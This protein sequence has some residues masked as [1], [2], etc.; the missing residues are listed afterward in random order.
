M[1][2]VFRKFFTS[3]Y[4][5]D[6]EAAR[7]SR[8]LNY[9]LWVSIGLLVIS[10]ILSFYE[11]KSIT[12]FFLNPI[13]AFILVLA[14]LLYVGKKGYVRI[15]SF[16]LITTAWI[17][18]LIQARL[19]T[20]IYDTAFIANSVIILLA[21]LLLDYRF[22]TLFS[23]LAI[24]TGWGLA[25][26]QTTSGVPSTPDFPYNI[27]RDYTLIFSLLMVI[28]YL[29]IDGLRNA[30]SRSRQN[31]IELSKS[32]KDL[33]VLQ[34]DL[35]KRVQE[36]TIQLEQR[37]VASQEQTR[38]LEA[39]ADVSRSIAALQDIE[40]LLPALTGL[41]S[42]R[43]GFYHAG[44]FLVNEASDRVE[45]RSA[46]SPGGKLLVERGY[47]VETRP[48]TLVGFAASQVKS[49][50]CLHVDSDPLFSPNPDLPETKS[51]VALPLLAGNRVIGVLD[52]QSDTEDFFTKE[53][54]IVL[55]TLA[56]QV[57][58]AIQNASLFS[59]TR[60]ALAE[61]E[62]VYN[63]YVLNGWQKVSREIQNKGYRFSP[64]V[65]NKLS[66][67][68]DGIIADEEK[69]ERNIKD[70]AGGVSIPI[71]LRGQTIGTL[72]I[73]PNSPGYEWDDD[74]LA[75]IQAAA[76][77]AALALENARLFEETSSRAER[78]RTVS[79]I[80]TKIR[81]TNNPDE[82]INIAVNELKQALKIKEARIIPI[83]PPQSRE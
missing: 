23:I 31:A 2:A 3:P 46:S 81:S 69:F 77:R 68:Q 73:V 14:I 29:T 76:D 24:F 47:M 60:K 66:P 17:A 65:V 38:L 71:K 13:S 33:L 32:N 62:N 19:Y 78:E 54:L 64:G 28:S 42:E 35:E 12:N 52:I 61:A 30:I 26:F 25:Y 5:D 1:L 20:G 16:I 74:E 34:T 45:L 9:I 55:N 6:E 63:R 7:A 51:E 43:F 58:T 50:V 53:Y 57:A 44:I 75:L 37:M 80:T 72:D 8:I 48:D 18:L 56:N 11:E 27:A 70:R 79:Q 82:M 59:E 4:Y 83:A 21:G 15:A 40:M 41:L 67:I 22:S 49:R 36:R 39:I 10:R